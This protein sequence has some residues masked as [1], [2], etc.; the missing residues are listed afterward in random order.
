MDN[1]IKLLSYSGIILLFTMLPGCV[2]PDNH[3]NFVYT[4]VIDTVSKSRE[5][6]IPLREVYP[7]HQIVIRKNTMN[8]TCKIG[9]EPIPP[10]KTGI[11]GGSELGMEIDTFKYLYKPYKATSGS[12]VFDHIFY[13][14]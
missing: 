13:L 12:L 3:K 7:Y 2:V 6:A 9:V 11:L 4:V 8:D 1:S 10:C 5:I 14:H